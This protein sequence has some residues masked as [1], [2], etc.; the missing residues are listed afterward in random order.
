MSSTNDVPIVHFLSDGE[1]A[2][3][4]LDNNKHEDSDEDDD[5]VKTGEKMAIDDMVKLCDQ[6]ID[7]MKQSTF[8]SVHQT[9]LC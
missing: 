1:I 6:L 5:I 8:I 2:E 7:G 9:F 4:V 3:V